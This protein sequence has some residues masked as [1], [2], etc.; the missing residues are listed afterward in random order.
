MAS[1]NIHSQKILILDFGSQYTQLIA[2]RI[3]EA[4]VYCEI[5]D[6]DVSKDD[7]TAFE[8]QGIV[9]SGSPE[10]ANTAVSPRPPACVYYAGVPKNCIFYCIHTNAE[11]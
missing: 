5:W 8:P 10:S 7:F 6:Y 11:E 9:L 1:T 3:R 4:G 2:R